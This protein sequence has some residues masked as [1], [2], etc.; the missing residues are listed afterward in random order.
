MERQSEVSF[1]EAS[2]VAKAS[3]VAGTVL[4]ALHV[5]AHLILATTL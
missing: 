3:Q 4:N 5:L 2:Q 1:V